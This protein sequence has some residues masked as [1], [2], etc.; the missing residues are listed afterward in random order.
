MKGCNVHLSSLK[1]GE[2]SREYS[3]FDLEKDDPIHRFKKLNKP[4]EGY[5]KG[6]SV[7]SEII[8]NQRQNENQ[9]EKKRLP[10]KKQKADD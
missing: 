8:E 9:C 3:R 5:I 7:Q 1:R 10:S 4:Q 6:K 2:S